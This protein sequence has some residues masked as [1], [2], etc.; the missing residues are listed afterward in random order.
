MNK[1]TRAFVECT[2]IFNMGEQKKKQKKRKPEGVSKRILKNVVAA[3]MIVRRTQRFLH[4]ALTAGSNL[5]KFK[6]KKKFK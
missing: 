3:Y 6:K 4:A 1:S 2:F 5:V